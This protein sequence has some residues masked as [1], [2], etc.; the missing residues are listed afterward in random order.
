MQGWWGAPGY[1]VSHVSV[2]WQPRDVHETNRHGANTGFISYITQHSSKRI[3]SR[4][5]YL[6]SVRLRWFG[7]DAVYTEVVVH[8]R[9]AVYG[10]VS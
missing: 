6:R 9:E 5:L 4:R 10:N 8:N 2:A 3:R 7:S 1:R